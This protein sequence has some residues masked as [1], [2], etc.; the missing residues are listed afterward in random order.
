MPYRFLLL[1]HIQ[2]AVMGEVLDIVYSTIV[3]YPKRKLCLIERKFKK[4]GLRGK[5]AFTVLIHYTSRILHD[6][7]LQT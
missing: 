2:S 7:T 4:R 3:T 1:Q 6:C 5:R